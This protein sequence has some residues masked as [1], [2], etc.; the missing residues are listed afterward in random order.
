MTVKDENKTI[1]GRQYYV[2]QMP[3]SEALVL[4]LKLTRILGGA[5]G[6][7]APALS[8]NAKVDGAGRS[9]AMAGAMGA[10]F[11]NATEQEVFGLM[12]DV[13][14]TA[15]VEGERIQL[16]KHF[17]GEYLSDVYKVFFWVLGVN[18]ASFFGEGGLDGLLAKFQKVMLAE[19]ASQ[20]K[21]PQA[22]TPS[23]G[24]P[25]TPDVAV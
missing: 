18:F 9:A 24:A 7:L 14:T 20:Q 5:I 17:Q 19:L 15:K 13:V 16:D 6:A 1:N 10:L 22:S 3:P 2:V 23:S 11:A 8:S 21:P 12:R 4:Q 25:S